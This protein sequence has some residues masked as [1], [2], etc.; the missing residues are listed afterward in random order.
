MSDSDFEQV[1]KHLFHDVPSIDRHGW[2][3]TLIPLTNDTQAI[4]AGENPNDVVAVATRFSKGR[5]LIFAHNGYTGMFL[6]S[7][8]SNKQFIENCRRWLT[9]GKGGEFISINDA[10]NMSSI[11]TKDKILVWDGH[12]TKSEEFTNN[13]VS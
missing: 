8:D 10:T 1:A 6:N 7:G 5:C 13:L 9:H 4:L 2:P 12:N 3:G 11:A